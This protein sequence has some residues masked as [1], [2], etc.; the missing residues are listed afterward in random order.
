MFS[1]SNLRT[2]SETEQRGE[3]S[4]LGNA[5]ERLRGHAVMFNVTE[6]SNTLRSVA[7]VSYL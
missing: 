3:L 2:K 5:R 7:M 1:D 4:S 6:M